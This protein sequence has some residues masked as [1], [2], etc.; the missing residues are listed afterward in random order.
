MGKA[1]G[2]SVRKLPVIAKANFC[3]AVRYQI[4]KL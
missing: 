1:H 2:Q 4:S 3:D